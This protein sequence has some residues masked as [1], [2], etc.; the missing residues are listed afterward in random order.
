MGCSNLT[1]EIVFEALFRNGIS[2][3]NE[4]FE[5]ALM[6][7]K[8]SK[9]INAHFTLVKINRCVGSGDPHESNEKKVNG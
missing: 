4:N 7:R 8:Q 5:K 9:K 6:N 2:H 3:P 1:L